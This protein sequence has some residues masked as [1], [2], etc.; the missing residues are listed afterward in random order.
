MIYLIEIVFFS[1]VN[2][3][4]LMIMFIICN[5]SITSNC[6]NDATFVRIFVTR[7]LILATAEYSLS[8]LHSEIYSVTVNCL[9]SH[10]VILIN[11]SF[12]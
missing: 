12:D 6:T 9:C 2:L 8:Q 1:I 4:L 7:K 5:I 11:A 3:I 10:L